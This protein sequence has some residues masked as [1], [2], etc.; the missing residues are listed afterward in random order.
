MIYEYE[1]QTLGGSA[2]DNLEAIG[3]RLQGLLNGD[4]TASRIA[5]GWET[6]QVNTLNDHQGVN[7]LVVVY[8]REKR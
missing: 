4:D 6:W 1:V 8:R 3:D 5:A 7:G 2:F